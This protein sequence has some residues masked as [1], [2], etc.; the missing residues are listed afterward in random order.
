MAYV[1]AVLALI[2]AVL[3]IGGLPPRFWVEF[4]CNYRAHRRLMPTDGVWECL[5]H[6]WEVT[7]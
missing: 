5:R 4:V 1:L 7:T 2:A 6:A 3:I